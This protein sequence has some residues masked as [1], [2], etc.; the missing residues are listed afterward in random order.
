M[1]EVTL[2]AETGRASGKSAARA[3]RR[4]G[5][6]PAVVYGLGENPVSVALSDHDL[7]QILAGPGGANTLINLDYD[8]RTDLVLA[9]QIHRHPVRHHL[10]HVD[11]IRISR[12]VAVS[13]E[14]PIHPVG[15]P[16]GVR[17]GGVL[18]QVLF[19]LSI[20]AKPGDLP[21]ALEIDVSGL[22]IGDHVSVGD[23]TLPAGVATTIDA[24][25]Q[26]AHVAQP[27]LEVPEPE[28]AEEVEEGEEA[29]A[30]EGEGEAPAADAEAPAEEG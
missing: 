18:T 12:D 2:R 4:A 3:V 8:G 1:E 28:A 22:D 19:S 27:R 25:T 20:E 16:S 30:G 21:R 13:A 7:A 9:R 11:L 23:L 5:N 10:V 6:V 14:V 24:D 29:E 26:V 15:E 17:D